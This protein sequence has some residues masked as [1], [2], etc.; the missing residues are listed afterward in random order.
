MRV[1][2]DAAPGWLTLGVLLHLGNQLAR[3][4]GWLAVLRAAGLRPRGRDVLAAWVAGAGCGGVL[5][6]RG[7][8][9]VRVLLVRHRLPG[10]PVGVL[11]GTLVAEAVGDAAL[12]LVFAAPLLAAGLG[13]AP[14][15]A[16]IIIMVIVAVAAG[17]L[18][19]RSA[20]RGGRAAPLLQGIV[21]GCAPLG[22]PAA[23][24]RRV[25]PWQ[26]ASR[27]LRAAS[28]A[29][30]LAAFA[31]P[32][33]P[34]AVALVMLAQG[35]GRLVPF[36][37]VGA[38]TGVALLAAGF[39]QVTGAHVGVTTLAA[40]LVGTSLVLTVCGVALAAA[41]AAW[42]GGPRLLRAGLRA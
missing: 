13:R 37:P 35:G 2:L 26:L 36:A 1:A 14:G 29:C 34:A 15:P 4:R 33:S 38:A 6:A 28:L 12:G 41:V 30:L 19:A 7:G 23:F 40:F 11:T 18:V 22:A 9:A 16:T 20:G 25:T 32:V 27:L 8:D 42:M 10:A 17:A 21:R 39:P 24:A 31:L 5:S 3:G